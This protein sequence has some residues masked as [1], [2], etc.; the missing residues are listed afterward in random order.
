MEMKEHRLLSVSDPSGAGEARR[1]AGSLAASLGFDAQLTEKAALV[2]SEAA[3]NLA[4]HAHGGVLL[5]RSLVENGTRGFAML[6]LDRGPGIADVD[7]CL[8]DGFSTAGSLGTGLGAIRRLST[9]FDIYSGPG[10]TA[11]YSD[12]WTIPRRSPQDSL[13]MG[14]VCVAKPG[15]EE[16]GD[17]WGVVQTA[18]R[19]MVL[20]VDGLGHGPAAAE[21]AGEAMRIFR[22]HPGDDA[23]TSMDRL[24]HGL[25]H[26]RGAAASIAELDRQHRVI[27]FAGIGN[28]AGSVVDRASSRSMVSHH[29]IVGQEARRIQEFTYPWPEG[30]LVVL[31]SDGIGSRWNLDAYPGLA[32]RHPML[33]AGILYRDFQR[34]RDDA[35]VVVLRE[36][37]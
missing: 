13:A 6:A 22:A 23:P 8:R 18:E 21:A 4:K 33:A 29:G 14:A 5:L 19:S 35:T 12:L 24:H 37:A 30:A 32:A 25:R 31:H 17:A 27:R 3:T 11:V 1:A 15:E 26:T 2:T 7:R 28:V 36:A 9:V 20:V 16:C 34:G 10:G